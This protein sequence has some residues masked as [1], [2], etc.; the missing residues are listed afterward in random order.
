M[1]NPLA[2]VFA[3]TDTAFAEMGL[4]SSNIGQTNG[5][6][7]GELLLYHVVNGDL[8]TTAMGDGDR[9]PTLNANDSVVVVGDGTAVED[10]AGGRA[11]VAFGNLASSNGVLHVVDAVLLPFPSRQLT[12]DMFPDEAGDAGAASRSGGSTNNVEVA[13]LSAGIAAAAILAA[14][15][16]AVHKRRQAD[17]AKPPQV[18][19]EDGGWG[20]APG[21]R[22]AAVHPA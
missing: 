1:P 7:L 11:S 20:T 8:R 14:A 21:W 6:A 17:A 3:P 15:A 9:L 2:Q 22:G 18:A 12:L 13:A 10:A 5:T 19:P 4:N 16:F